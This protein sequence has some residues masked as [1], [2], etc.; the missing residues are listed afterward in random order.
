MGLGAAGGI[1]GMTSVGSGSLM[2][3]LLL[4]VYPTI[5]AKQ[6][7]GTN[8][9]QAVPLTLAGRGRRDRL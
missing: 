1:I 6:L 7:V 4:F 3:V 5:G 9:T 8:L 2:I